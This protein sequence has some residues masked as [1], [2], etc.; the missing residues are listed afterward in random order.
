MA[1]IRALTLADVDTLFAI[2][3]AATAHPWSH[4]QFVDGLAGNEFGWA[5]T[6]DAN[7]V[8]FA[9][10]NKVLDEATLLD[11]VVRADMQRRG[12]AHTLL[13]FGLSE[14]KAQQI[15][16]CLLEVR[17]TNGAAIELYKALGFIEDGRR[18][19][20]YPTATGREDALLMSTIL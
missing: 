10:F 8:G 15:V 18:R 11:I 2:E 13:Q 6:L 20:Y 3:Q 1:L 9:L 5:I 12:F 4:R 7:L 17:V 16:R 19:N 14:L